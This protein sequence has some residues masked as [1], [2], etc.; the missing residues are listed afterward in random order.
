MKKWLIAILIL[1]LL[2]AA[3][4]YLLVPNIISVSQT[5]SINANKDGLYRNLLDEGNWAQWWP[6]GTALE[7]DSLHPFFS[8]NDYIYQIDNKGFSSFKISITNRTFIAITSL[9]LFASKLDSVKLSWEA[10]IPTSY[11]PL[12]R[13]QVYLKSRNLKKDMKTVLEKMQSF[14]SKTENI[15]GYDIRHASVVDTALIST[16]ASSK[17][18]PGTQFI[19]GLIDQLKNYI[20][21]QSAKETGF[22]MLNISTADSINFLTK[23]A[24]PTD[25]QLPSSGNITYKWMLGGGNILV[26][27]VKGGPASI[28][29]AFQQ[30]ENYVNDHQHR[31][32]AIPFQSMVTDR[33]QEPDTSK[34]VT[35]IY[36]PIF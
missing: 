23:V 15:Y 1:L 4:I 8:Y 14:F 18:Y 28:S 19:Y 3:S 30:I 24:I 26:T 22:P 32:P 33:R 34:W 9:N 5:I 29:K 12:K 25:K 10:R 21:S 6:A 11:N 35:R 27:E 13:L 17:G 36:Y 2:L 16:F 7:K 20:A 31:S